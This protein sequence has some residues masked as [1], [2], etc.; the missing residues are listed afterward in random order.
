[1]ITKHA[2]AIVYAF[3]CLL[4]KETDNGFFGI[5]FLEITDQCNNL[6]NQ[7]ILVIIENENDEQYF[8][9]LDNQYLE[10]KTNY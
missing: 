5:T 7:P 2:M 1:M 9:K 4:Q 8:I 10:I 3:P 6:S